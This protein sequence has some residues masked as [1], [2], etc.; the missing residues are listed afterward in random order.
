MQ[1]TRI[2]RLRANGSTGLPKDWECHIY[3]D[4]YVV[5]F[6][7][8]GTHLQ[9]R[10]YLSKSPN[11]EGVKKAEGKMSTGYWMVSDELVNVSLSKP[12]S[13]PHPKP[14]KACLALQEWMAGPCED[15]VF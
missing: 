4:R 10:E 5:K 15:W 2:L 13:P 3:S 6:G 8:T 7:R 12:A 1:P 9:E 11:S 14:T